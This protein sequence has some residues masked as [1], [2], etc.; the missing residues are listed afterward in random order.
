MGTKRLLHAFATL[1]LSTALACA[2]GCGLEAASSPAALD[3]E[4]L[5]MQV[6]TLSLTRTELL[7][8]AAEELEG[9]RIRFVMDDDGIDIGLLPDIEYGRTEFESVAS[10]YLDAVHDRLA[11]GGLIDSTSFAIL[12]ER[13]MTE[14]ADDG[15]VLAQIE[16]ILVPWLSVSFGELDADGEL[17][18]CNKV[19]LDD[20]GAVSVSIDNVSLERSGT[21]LSLSF[22]LENLLVEVRQARAWVPTL[23]CN[24]FTIDG[25]DIRY[26]GTVLTAT[27]DA[28]IGN[29]SQPFAWPKAWAACRDIAP[30]SLFYPEGLP[31]E[32]S[33]APGGLDYA[34]VTVSTSW[35]AGDLSSPELDFDNPVTDA[36]VA[37]VSGIGGVL[38]GVA[39]ALG[40]VFDEVFGDGSACDTVPP[41]ANE[42]ASVSLALKF[43]HFAIQN[44]RAGS[45]GI[46][47][48]YTVDEDWDGVL[49]GLDN[50][51]SV[52]NRA[53]GDADFDGVGDACDPEVMSISEAEMAAAIE[54]FV[55]WAY[56]A[57]CMGD[58]VHGDLPEYLG[59]DDIFSLLDDP[60][61]IGR[62]DDG[63]LP[64]D[65]LGDLM[66]GYLD[67][68]RETYVGGPGPIMERPEYY[69]D[70][71]AAFELARAQVAD[72]A[73][74]LGR[75]GL[76]RL[77]FT[78]RI[79]SGG[80]ERLAVMDPVGVMRHLTAAELIT[81]RA[82]A[83]PIAVRPLGINAGA[84]AGDPMPRFNGG[85]HVVAAEPNP[86]NPRVSIRFFQP[87]V[88]GVTVDVLDVR[89]RRVRNLHSGSLPVGEHSVT[90]S[91]DDERGR[92]LPSGVYL[93]VVR[94]DAGIA[95]H[96]LTMLQ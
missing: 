9:R 95:T 93:A 30:Q 3:R 24:V 76:L 39:S 69:I 42:P 27:V 44:V 71:D 12:A 94:S 53:Q 15:P 34:T 83:A 82:A 58:L 67:H 79:G 41:E 7:D 85:A 89:G 68:W 80:V 14:L 29:R 13:V 81:L 96:K 63:L 77:E 84:P 6:A 86:F 56:I 75:P 23:W 70:R 91:G 65:L 74:R 59:A 52:S 61:L 57:L 2:A 1:A 45:L 51:P 78:A 35:I 73:A 4:L 43:T 40:C 10:D 38:G 62:P 17:R 88:G 87:R 16:A 5:V 48:D 11:A 92:R 26:P 46:L 18:A 54:Y 32:S 33:A 72:L 64:P 28:E 25:L 47:F 22:D 21:N 19:R 36:V 50:C 60:E 66:G 8:I 37:L 55:D 20:V 31:T 90:W 49:T